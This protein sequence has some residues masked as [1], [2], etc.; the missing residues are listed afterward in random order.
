MRINPPSFSSSRTIEDPENIV[1]ELKKV[2]EA[3]HVVDIER[4]ELAAYQLRNVARTWYE[5]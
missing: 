4:V 3:M 5:Q 1:E 2:F